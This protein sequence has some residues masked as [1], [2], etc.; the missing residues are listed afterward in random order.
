[1]DV[2][3]GESRTA[4]H[5]RLVSAD[6]E[7]CQIGHLRSQACEAC[8]RT[9]PRPTLATPRE[10]APHWT[11]MSLA[12][13]EVRTEVKNKVRT[14]P[15]LTPSWPGL[16]RPS[17]S[18]TRCKDV[19]PRNKSGDGEAGGRDRSVIPGRSA[20]EGNEIHSHARLDESFSLAALAGDDPLR[21]SRRSIL[22]LRNRRKAASRRIVQSPLEP[23]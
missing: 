20:A 19:D 6:L 23:T 10:R 5:A 12:I 8:G 16:S 13:A 18:A 21:I 7:A 17:T 9:A 1:M 14:Y 15:H 2:V 22:V 11:R 4:H 3:E